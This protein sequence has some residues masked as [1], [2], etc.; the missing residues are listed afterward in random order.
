MNLSKILIVLS[1]FTYSHVCAQ[2][3]YRKGFVITQ[4][5]D[6]LHGLIDYQADHA[7]SD[8]CKFR[9]NEKAKTQVYYTE[10]LLG[11]QVEDRKFISKSVTIYNDI[12]E[13][14]FLEIIVSGKM[15]L[16]YYMDLSRKEYLFINPQN[17]SRLV[18]L[19]Y[20]KITT[21]VRNEAG[22][23]RN[24]TIET[25]DHIDTLKK[26]MQDRPEFFSEIE[27]IKVP[28]LSNLIQLLNLYNDNPMDATLS[29][30]PFIKKI[31]ARKVFVN[32]TLC[33]S[34]RMQELSGNGIMGGANLLIGITPSDERFFFKTGIYLSDYKIDSVGIERIYKIPIMF[35]HRFPTNKIQPFYALGSN[36]Y[37]SKN[38]YGYTWALQAGV[39][40]NF[41]KSV[42]MSV[43]SEIEF[44]GTIPPEYSNLSLIAGIQIKL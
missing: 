1:I 24:T 11:Y 38:G 33:Y 29:S 25:T 26:Y 3:D 35:E 20:R 2:S 14:V 27:R 16:Y 22:L 31:P 13:N 36:M 18:F 42:S 8:K 19:P 43:A 28:T 9:L 5:G 23:G 30:K 7:L 10:D 6:T 17:D 39:Y 34:S 40:L 44:T 12:T 15:N 32:P 37:F 21:I 41:S 4:K